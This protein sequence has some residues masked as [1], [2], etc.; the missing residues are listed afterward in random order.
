MK[1]IEQRPMY[2]ERRWGW[3]RVID[4]S[5]S[6]EKQEV[7]TKR[8]YVMEGKNLSYQMHSNRN[9]TWTILSGSGEMV[10]D[11]MIF[12]IQAGD[13]LAI[14]QGVKHSVRALTNIDFIEVQTGTQVVEE[15]AVR[16]F[17]EWDEIVQHCLKH[18]H[19]EKE[20]V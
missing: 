7:L 15:D 1:H 18:N 13:V 12:P 4:Y 8:M 2:E 16:L 20:I 6:K 9:E 14:P 10:M 3:Y 11:G 17:T 5:T 19:S